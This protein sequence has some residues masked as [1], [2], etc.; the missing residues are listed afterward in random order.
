MG[1]I[2]NVIINEEQLAYLESQKGNLILLCWNFLNAACRIDPRSS[3]CANIRRQKFHLGFASYSKEKIGLLPEAC[4]TCP[5]MAQ[6]I[7]HLPSELK[8]P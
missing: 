5:A 8:S 2:K 4:A 1:D 7:T 3:D 6:A